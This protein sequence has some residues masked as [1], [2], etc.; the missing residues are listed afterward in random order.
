VETKRQRHQSLSAA[1]KIPAI[2]L[3][4]PLLANAYTW[5]FTSQPSQCQNVSIAVEGSGQPPYSLL[6]IPSGPSPLANNVEVRTIQSIPFPGNSDTL[7]FKLKY[8][9]N[10]SFVAVVSRYPPIYMFAVIR[11]YHHITCRSATAADLALVAP[12]F[13]SLFSDPPTRVVTMP[14]RVS[15]SIGFLTS[16][17]LVDSRNAALHG[18]GGRR[19]M[20]M[21]TPIIL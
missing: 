4:A 18:F 12:A 10:S 3:F 7:S 1:M 19:L 5:K 11:S 21:G 14:P 2:F 17:P 20:L 16:I 13:P 9:E 8:P 6:I 15:R